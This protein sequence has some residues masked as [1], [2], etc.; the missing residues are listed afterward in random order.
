MKPRN[1]SPPRVARASARAKENQP[2]Q[3]Y[4][5]RAGARLVSRQTSFRMKPPDPQNE[6]GP[7]LSAPARGEETNTALGSQDRPQSFKG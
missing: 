2:P 5:R 3:H 6:K 4:R 1:S 7:E